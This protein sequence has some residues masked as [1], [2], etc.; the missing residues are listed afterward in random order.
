M[1]TNYEIYPKIFNLVQFFIALH[2]FG[3]LDLADLIKIKTGFDS[4]EFLTKRLLIS[5]NYKL[6]AIVFI[7]LFSNK[8]SQ[9]SMGHHNDDNKVGS[10]FFF[11]SALNNYRKIKKEHRLKMSNHSGIIRD[12]LVHSQVPRQK[13][14]ARKRFR[15]SMVSFKTKTVFGSFAHNVTL[16]I[17]QRTIQ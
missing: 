13:D 11:N 1:F 8:N 9:T 15:S 16:N 6:V 10:F 2:L 3:M 14:W 7:L 17:P 12:G 5:R 4:Y